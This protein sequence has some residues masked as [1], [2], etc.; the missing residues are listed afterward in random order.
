MLRTSLA[1]RAVYLKCV[2]LAR[3]EQAVYEGRPFGSV[4]CS[5]GLTH[6]YYTF[7]FAQQLT[8]PHHS[9]QEGPLYFTSPRKVQLFGVC[10]EGAAEQYNY[11]IDENNTIGTDGSQSHGPNTYISML[12]HAFQHYGFGEMACHIHCDNCAGSNIIKYSKHS[13]NDKILNLHNLSGPLHTNS[14]YFQDIIKIA[15]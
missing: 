3:E 12:H 15:M 5:N 9:R 1:E 13:L 11:L 6:V 10:I 2:H 4:P 7:D 14:I 8:L